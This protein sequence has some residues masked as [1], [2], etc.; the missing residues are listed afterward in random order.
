M[1]QGS[2]KNRKTDF[3]FQRQTEVVFRVSA[4]G[5]NS[6][7]DKHEGG[8]PMRVRCVFCGYETYLDDKVFD[9]GS[10]PIRCY[11]CHA[12]IKVRTVQGLIC[13]I[14]QS[15]QL[16]ESISLLAAVPSAD[17]NL[18]RREAVPGEKA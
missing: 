15:K 12:M 16:G 10:G 8:W 3:I 14:I 6:V 4:F 13:S 17:A 1:R 11:C 7:L 9:E 2:M 18:S 5:E